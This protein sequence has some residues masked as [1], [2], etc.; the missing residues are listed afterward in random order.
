MRVIEAARLG[1]VIEALVLDVTSVLP[2]D[3]VR[4]LED[5]RHAEESPAGRRALDMIL[6]NAAKAAEYGAPICQDTGV[7]TVYL[8]LGRG[9][10]VEGDLAVE[11]AAAVAR[12][13]AAGAL[14]SS[15][16]RDPAGARVNTGDNSPPLLEV[17]L[18]PESESTV[19]VMAKGGG[20]EMA[21]RAT[22]LRPGAGWRGVLEFALG[23]VEE[24]GAQSCPPL[25]LGVGIGGGFDRA[26]ALAK[27]ALLVPL[28]ILNPDESLAAHEA[29]LLREVNTL[30]IGP[31]AL[32][33][34]MTCIGARIAEAPCHMANLPVAVSLSCHAL[35][36]KTARV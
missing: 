23:V 7:F 5:A 28:D 30:G 10:A 20:S 21:S 9:T 6:E 31:G 27:K 2:D 35:R 17:E 12:A 4:A 36:R 3:V 26:P 33:G 25:V 11:A 13:T 29:E 8:D 1:A 16:V 22:M 34:R 32:G 15:L 24:V 18:V 19:A 14:R